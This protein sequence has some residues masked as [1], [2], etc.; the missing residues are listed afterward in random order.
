MMSKSTLFLPSIWP[1]TSLTPLSLFSPPG[2]WGGWVPVSERL[3]HSQPVALWWRQRLWRQQ[4][5]AM[6]W[7][8]TRTYSDTETR[9]LIFNAKKITLCYLFY[10][11]KMNWIGVKNARPS[12][13]SNS[14]SPPPPISPDLRKCSDKEFRCS[15]GSCIAEHWYCDGDGDCKDGSDEDNCRE[16][17]THTNPHTLSLTPSHTMTWRLLWCRNSSTT[18]Q[19]SSNIQTSLHPDSFSI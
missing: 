12:S 3:L 15:D 10:L 11:L 4:W 5:W 6:R 2:M 14:S 13:Y 7:E 1:I 19:R 8:Q 16:L 18:F 17:R 9:T